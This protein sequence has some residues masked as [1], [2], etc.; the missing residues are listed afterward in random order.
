MKDSVVLISI[1]LLEIKSYEYCRLIRQ[2]RVLT[3]QF[4]DCLLF[5]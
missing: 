3:L 4:A 1:S 5:G 2:N